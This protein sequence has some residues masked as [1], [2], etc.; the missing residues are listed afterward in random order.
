MNREEEVQHEDD[1]LVEVRKASR[2][3]EKMKRQNHTE[4]FTN[5][6]MRIVI[7]APLIYPYRF[8]QVLV[9]LGYEPIPPERRYSYI[10]RQYFQYYPGLYGYAKAIVQQEGWRGLYRG[11]WIFLVDDIT[12]QT[13][14][15]MVAPKAGALVSKLPL[16]VV[17]RGEDVPDNE[18]NVETN[19]AVIVR[20]TRSFLSGVLAHTTVEIITHP[21][22]VIQVRAI[23]QHVGK[24]TYYSSILGAVREIYHEEGFS[25]F[26]VGLVPSILGHIVNCFI[27]TMVQ[28]VFEL[29]A[30]KTT[31]EYGKLIVRGIIE[32]ALLLYLPSTY[33][34]PFR[35]VANQMAV[36]NVRLQAGCGLRPQMPTYN[37]WTDCYHFLKST[38]QA[39]RGLSII[40]P[41]I[42]FPNHYKN[43]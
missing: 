32:T 25:G 31:N 5:R 16:R 3:I 27:A 22:H 39:Y 13:I 4:K 8:V 19:R 23:A 15:S 26:Y 9:Q 6:V 20:A 41:R 35:L 36:N 21:L 28:V 1:L 12:T 7:T 38:G 17:S 14:H 18:E 2:N 10:F 37:G 42:V 34:Y 33:A 30:L 24:E 43:S 40:F 11:V 29:I